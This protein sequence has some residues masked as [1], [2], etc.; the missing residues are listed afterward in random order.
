VQIVEDGDERLLLGDTAEQSGGGI[1]EAEAPLLGLQR[2][3]RLG[4]PE[5]APQ[6]RYELADLAGA[7]AEIGEEGRGGGPLGIRTDRLNPGPER[8][9]SSV[10]GAAPPHDPAGGQRSTGDELL[11]RSGLPD[12]RLADQG[13]EPTV[14][15]TRSLE[16]TLENAELIGT[17]D[18]RT[19]DER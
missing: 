16:L 1:E 6:R 14:A 12:A 9:R 18:E 5:G 10:L 19:P 4:P 2:R 13:H 8:G 7:R 11:G 17:T 15:G 3:R